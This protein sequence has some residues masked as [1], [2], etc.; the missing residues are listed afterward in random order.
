MGMSSD[1]VLRSGFLS[2]DR[3][4]LVEALREMIPA[5][6]GWPDGVIPGARVL[7]KVNMLAAKPPERAITTHPELVA[8]VA[9][10]LIEKGCRILIGD[11]PGGAVKGIKRY[12]EKCGY[13][14]IA[15]EL[16]I[17]LVNFES[18]GSDSSD[19]RGR[20]ISIARPIVEAD[21]R[22]SLCK[23]KTHVF[24]RLTNAVKNAFGVV[25]GFGKALLHSYALRPSDLAEYLVEIYRLADFQM[26]IMDAILAMDGKGPSTD[27][28][29]RLDGIL[30]VAVNGPELDMVMTRLAGLDP[31]ELDTSRIALRRGLCRPPDEISVSGLE[32]CSLNEFQVP[33]V[34]YFNRLPTFLGTLFRILFK[35]PPR[36]TDACTACRTCVDGCPV[37]AIVIRDGKA[38]MSGRKCILCLC[39]HEIC[40][41][42][43]VKVRIPF[44]R[45]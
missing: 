22:I 4:A 41:E 13:L 11:S 29:P 3:T 31:L 16:G 17:E 43:A 20:D 24:C 19:F 27:G 32:D 36:A 2:Y 1:V 23:F 18:S 42:R 8:A 21:V 39:C 45:N 28:H 35:R 34:S 12:W 40:P 7:L 5:A 30:G 6:G 26:T 14:A 37:G 25:P 44:T 38:V 15:E 10:L 9:V 33:G